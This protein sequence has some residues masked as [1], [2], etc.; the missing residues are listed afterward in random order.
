M[1]VSVVHQIFPELWHLVGLQFL[2]PFGYIEPK[3][4]EMKG[5]YHFQGGK[6]L[7]IGTKSSTAFFLP[8]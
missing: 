7:I 4:C 6:H 8:Q 5:L 2:V 3:S 1:A